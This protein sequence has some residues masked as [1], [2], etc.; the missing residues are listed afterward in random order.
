VAKAVARTD[1]SR[2][3]IPAGETR[4]RLERDARLG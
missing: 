1:R 2:D 3:L 4:E